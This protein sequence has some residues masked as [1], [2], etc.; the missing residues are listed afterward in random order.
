MH[1]QERV[2]LDDGIVYVSDRRLTYQRETYA[3]AN[4]EYISVRK[5]GSA[6]MMRSPNWKKASGIG[7][8]YLCVGICSSVVSANL[9]QLMLTIG[10]GFLLMVGGMILFQTI[11]PTYLIVVGGNAG[12]QPLIKGKD[13]LFIEKVADALNQAIAAQHG[14]V[15]SNSYNTNISHSFNNASNIALGNSAQTGQPP[16]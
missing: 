13:R 14:N 1:Q 16:R 15:I 6:Q 8:L 12:P 2:F 10:A 11:L 4:L 9:S 5:I 7:V 3:L